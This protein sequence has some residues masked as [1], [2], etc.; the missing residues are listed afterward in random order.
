MTSISHERLL[1]L[2][3]YNPLTGLMTWKKPTTNRVKA[4]SRAGS[5]SG[6]GYWQIGLDGKVYL[7]HRVAWFYV[8][9]AW[10]EKWIDHKNGDFTD[11]RFEN[12]RASSIS[13]NAG[14]TKM[15]ADNS[16]GLKGVYRKR[17]KFAARIRCGAAY[18]LGVFDT[19]E[20]AHAAYVDAAKKYFGDFA[21]AS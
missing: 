12:L 5:V 7:F 4:G 15:H 21:R 6:T 9:A 14:N 17:N 19:P 11:N 2:V 13:Q 8:T 10:P 20:E 1:E 16:V 18:N 3:E